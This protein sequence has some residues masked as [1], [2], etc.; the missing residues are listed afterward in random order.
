MTSTTPSVSDTGQHLLPCP[1]WCDGHPAD[2]VFYSVLGTVEVTVHHV[3]RVGAHAHH[4]DVE[5]LLDPAIAVYV[6]QYANR[7]HGDYDPGKAVVDVKEWRC[8]TPEEAE[9]IAADLIAA[10]AVLREAQR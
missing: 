3:A 8:E 1:S 10:A 7:T 5:P 4:R 2:E 9:Q 6:L